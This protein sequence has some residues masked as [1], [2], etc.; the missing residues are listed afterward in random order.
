MAETKAKKKRAK[1][2]EGP[3]PPSD[4][5]T[6]PSCERC[7]ALVLERMNGSVEPVL[8]MGPETARVLLVVDNPQTVEANNGSPD[9]NRDDWQVVMEAL[10]AAE[11]EFE[12]VVVGFA[13]RCAVCNP[14][15]KAKLLKSEVISNCRPW[16]HLELE[17]YPAVTAIIC[18][19]R[20]AAAAVLDIP[21]TGYSKDR[22]KIS[23]VSIGRRVLRVVV[24][25]HPFSVLSTP[26]EKEAFE[27]D[28][29]QL[30][31]ASHPDYAPFDMAVHQEDHLEKYHL[32][33]SPEV[34]A[35]MVDT[36]LQAPMVAF[37]CETRGL[38]PF[39]LPTPDPADAGNPP[40]FVTSIQ[41]SP[42][43]GEA[44]FLPV[45]HQEFNVWE[46][47]RKYQ[48]FAELTRF[49]Q[50]YKGTLV[51][52][53]GKFDQVG[54]LADFNVLP[55]LGLDPM[56]VDQLRRGMPARSLKKLAW[57]VSPF[58]GYE[59]AFKLSAV[60]G[61]EHDSFYHPL[62]Q[63][64][65]YG[66]LDV[67]VTIRAAQKFLPVLD[68]DP[69]LK[70]LSDYLA[71]A[72]GV[73]AQIEYD[74]WRIDLDYLEKYGAEQRE[75]V[76]RAKL[77]IREE[78]SEAVAVYEK[79][80]GKTFDPSSQKALSLL[81]FDLLGLPPIG[82][83]E[84]GAPS[85]DRAALKALMNQHPVIPVLLDMRKA[86]KAYSAFYKRWKEGVAA[87]GRLHFR[88]N[89]IK[90]RD[91]ETGDKGG[92]ETGRLS[93]SGMSGNVQQITK[94]PI[95]RQTFLPDRQGDVLIDIDFSTLEYVVAAIYSRDPKLMDAFK[96]GWDIHAA[97]AAE[98][99]GGTAEEMAKP[100][101]KPFRNKGKTMNFSSLYG[102][103]PENVAEQLGC[104][105]LEAEEFLENYRA[106]FPHLFAWIERAKRVARKS[107]RATSKFGRFRFLPDA[108]LA[109]TKPN[110]GRIEAALRQAVNGP[111]Q[112]DASDICLWGLVRVAEKIKEQDMLT[113]VKATIH[114]AIV[115]S[116]PA[117]EVFE[118]IDMVREILTHPGLDWLDGPSGPGVPLR[119][120]V[121]IGETWG[122]MEKYDE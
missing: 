120:S 38:D 46:D 95:I 32:V 27:M 70:F 4:L 83:T 84:K 30:Q 42:A 36:L 105:T 103:G 104:S 34:L 40:N 73:L 102:A 119:V 5:S 12:D 19:G 111:I 11:F 118:V 87:D 51:A 63:L 53:N 43:P 122:T 15:D 121:E 68:G 71:K 66:C 57:V 54:V 22:G 52:Y 3:P 17:K 75:R 117:E 55:Q 47:E 58:G 59:E 113:R 20:V 92:T 77:E 65:W 26:F 49:F 82:K 80:T 23:E 21:M 18:L 45:C 93:S 67:D 106:K 14:G 39:H 97:V 31:A 109:E 89:L 44:Y 10:S 6:L 33:D 101:N 91:L 114:D 24:S 50:E 28:F 100:E 115:L 86:E 81:L 76:L 90:F 108:K 98:M 8:F 64:F 7:P 48:W 78:A 69:K 41:F 16:L 13:A 85:T 110:R 88:Y 29:R 116:A 60:K 94:D 35:S 56:I 9:W 74:G 25:A 96:K 112:G 37:D 2:E 99:F 79:T 62:D 72:S 61:H 1:R 107:G